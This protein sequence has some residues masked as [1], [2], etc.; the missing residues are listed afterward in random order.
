LLITYILKSYDIHIDTMS[1]YYLYKETTYGF[2]PVERT[3]SFGKYFKKRNRIILYTEKG[4]RYARLKIKKN[5]NILIYKRCFLLR[6]K[7]YKSDAPLPK[8]VWRRL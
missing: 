3:I 2:M 1:G 7:L 8:R 4:K 5:E 6:K